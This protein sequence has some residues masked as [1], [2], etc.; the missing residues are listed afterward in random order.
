MELVAAILRGLHWVPA[1]PSQFH[2]TVIDIKNCS[3][4]ISLHEEEYEKFAF[5]IATINSSWPDERY[6]W[7]ILPQSLAFY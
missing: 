1:I 5:S 2:L 3:F 4:S 7:A 6:K